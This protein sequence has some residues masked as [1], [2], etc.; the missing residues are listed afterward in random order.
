MKKSILAVII[1]GALAG[2]SSNGSNNDSPTPEPKEGIADVIYNE[3]LH[4]A[5]INGDEGNSAAIIGDGNGNAAIKINDQAFTVQGDVIINDEGDIV[6][7]ITTEDGVAI[8][9]INDTAYTLSVSNGRLIVDS[10]KLKPEYGD[11]NGWDHVPTPDNDSPIIDG[12]WGISGAPTYGDIIAAGGAVIIKGDNDNF[13]TI[14]ADG[15]GNAGIVINGGEQTYAVKD[16]E[17][18]NY[19]T[20]ESVGHIQK[21]GENYTVR[22]DNGTEV[23]FRNDDGRLFAAVISRPDASNPIIDDHRP[24]TTPPTYGDIVTAGGA[25]IIKGDN[26]NFVTIKADGQGNAGIVINGGEQTYAVKNGELFNYETG[27]SVGHIQKDGE[28]Y[29]VRLDNGT[30]VVFRNDDGRL[31]AAVISRPNPDNDLPEYGE[32][33]WGIPGAPTYG[34]ILIVD[35]AAVIQGDNGNHMFVVKH[36][37]TYYFNVNGADASPTHKIVNGEVQTIAGE[38]TGIHVQQTENGVAF[39]TDNGTEIVFRNDD[40]RLFAAVIS[41]PNPDNDLPEYGEGDWGIPGAPTYGD[42]LIVDNAAVIQGDNGNHM[43]VVKHE[44]TYYFNVNGADASPT[45]KIVNGEVQ[46]IAGESTG[47]HVQQTEN[48]VAFRTDNGTEIVFRNDDGR[49]FA[50]VI[51]RPG[52]DNGKKLAYTVLTKNEFEKVSILEHNESEASILIHRDYEVIDRSTVTI[53]DRNGNVV[54]FDHAQ[55]AA[56]KAKAKAL[57]SEQRQQIKQTIK[58]KLQTRS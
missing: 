3:E 50:A 37:D 36:E 44:D 15:Q 14:R 57:S 51:S 48:G 34:D 41:R 19:D 47:I 39:R 8:A 16:G 18:F 27:E 58:T 11:D 1:A 6:G 30:E 49:L 9:Y 23:V 24:E 22:L 20:G 13:V 32:G 21:D 53:T 54:E 17:L 7:T 31:F 46:T 35:N 40:G 45:H 42:T 12:G 2:C 29:T 25:V 4:S 38:S 43:F 28:N 26:D 5:V 55:M 10:D 56:A 52:A 33:D